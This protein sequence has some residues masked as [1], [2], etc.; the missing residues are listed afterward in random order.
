MLVTKT[1]LS[2]VR[3]MQRTPKLVIAAWDIEE[4]LRQT[5]RS[6]SCSQRATASQVALV[7]VLSVL[8]RPLL[9]LTNKSFHGWNGY[10]SGEQAATAESNSFLIIM[11]S[12]DKY[13]F[14]VVAVI[15]ISLYAHCVPIERHLLVRMSREHWSGRHAF[16]DLRK[17]L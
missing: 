3:E 6:P 10:V 11:S 13:S 7:L 1:L 9:M 2:I 14:E 15:G 5:P 17:H 16:L 12:R 4:H 8:L